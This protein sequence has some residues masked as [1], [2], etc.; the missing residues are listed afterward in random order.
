MTRG[1]GPAPAAGSSPTPGCMMR[2]TNSRHPRVGDVSND[3]HL[4]AGCVR[5]DLEDPVRLVERVELR[6]TAGPDVA[7]RLALLQRR[8]AL[9]EGVHGHRAGGHLREIRPV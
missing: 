3:L 9:L 2:L 6:R 8:D 7:D 4:A 5:V 1:A